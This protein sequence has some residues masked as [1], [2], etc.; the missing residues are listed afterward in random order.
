MNPYFHLKDKRCTGLWNEEIL[1]LLPQ[2]RPGA[3]YTDLT[4]GLGAAGLDKDGHLIEAT[5]SSRRRPLA[6]KSS[7]YAAIADS[8]QL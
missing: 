4:D 7:S 2:V 1:S 3:Q 8:P 5:S 6:I